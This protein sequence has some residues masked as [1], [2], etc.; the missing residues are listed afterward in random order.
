MN[1]AGLNRSDRT[2][3][4]NALVQNSDDAVLNRGDRIQNCNSPTETSDASRVRAIVLDGFLSEQRFT[5]AISHQRLKP[6]LHKVFIVGQ[7]VGDR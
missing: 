2:L 4:E 5:L 3:N 1:D 7:G 6:S